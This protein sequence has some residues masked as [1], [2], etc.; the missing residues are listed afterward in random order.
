M[1]TKRHTERDRE[2]QRQRG[3]EAERHDRE[4]RERE[5]PT[6]AERLME[7]FPH[8]ATSF[9]IPVLLIFL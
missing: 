4:S 9:P 2:G 1:E 6:G 7:A 3:I 5:R 8:G